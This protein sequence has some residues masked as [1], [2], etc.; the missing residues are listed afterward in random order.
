MD[1]GLTGRRAL[2]TGASK[3]IGRA[4]A[5]HLA[6]AGARVAG[7]ARDVAGLEGEGITPIAADLSV[8]EGPEA[9]VRAAAAALGGL[10]IL[11]N[12]AGATRRGDFLALDEA[13]WAD[14][15]G[16]KFLG[17]VRCTRAAWPLL[18][19][20]GHGAVVN[21]GGVGGRV[22]SA[23]FTIGGSVNAA[24]MNLTKALADRGVREGVRVNLVNPGSVATDRLAGRIRSKMREAGCDEA[25]ARRLLAA[26]TGVARFAEAGEIAEVVAFL[27]GRRASYVQGALWDVDGGW[28]RAV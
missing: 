5:R 12:N 10:D 21:I 25:E 13:A 14:G 16:L 7:A 23:E 20:S 4:I 28:V 17:A 2:V 8:P 18:V 26:E 6:R 15:F 11:V 22:A 3:G 24:L 1:D 9:A 27:C 19:Q